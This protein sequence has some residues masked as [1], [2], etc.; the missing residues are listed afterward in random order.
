MSSV[1]IADRLKASILQSAIEGKLTKQLP[2]DGDARELLAE[3]E[4]EKA[5]L[6]EE[7]IIR[8]EK[9][10]AAITEEEIPFEIPENWVWVRMKDLCLLITD[11]AHH[12]PKYIES[13]VP[14]LSV[15]NIT[16]GFLDLE[17]TKFISQEEH[18]QLIKRCHP[19]KGDILLSKIGT[20]GVPLVI[21]TDIEFSI[22]VSLALLKI[23]KEVCNYFLCLMIQT[24]LA[25]Q[26]AKA[27][28]KGVGNKNWV[29]RDI[30]NMIIPLPPL[31]EQQRIVEAIEIALAKVDSLKEDEMKL[32]E[33]QKNFP[34]KLRASL[35]QS[36]IEGKLTK[37]LSEDGDA[38]ELLAEIEAEKARLVEE[39]I[40]RKEKPLP[41]ITEEEIPFEIPENWVW[42]RLGEITYNRG[43]K[44]PTNQFTYIDIS[45]INNKKQI[46]G[47]DLAI[48]EAK[49]APSRARKIVQKGDVIYSTVRPYLLNTC[50]IDKEIIPEPIVS[51]GFAVLSTPFL[52]MNQFLL[53][54]LISPFF[55]SY[56]NDN[57]NAKGV[58]YPAI[59][60]QKFRQGLVPL[61]PLAEQHRIVAELEKVLGKVEQLNELTQ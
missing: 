18:E 35:L 10:L 54:F 36:A 1:L 33:I 48:L 37:Q 40:I 13:G 7:K 27:G 5:R 22:F 21:E 53:Y 51:T 28:T 34:N 17:Q 14:F 8:K 30:S 55:N 52:V 57:E 38:R 24:P 46:L 50:I 58:A 32:Y 2:E 6:V 9:P 45:S 41:A 11:G 49:A 15:K 39:K 20:T 16:K 26:Q 61:P 31:S 19:E 4:A 59:N 3:I 60:D 43:Q 12:T 44:T 42:V 23:P 29:L 47:E 56:A 25:Q